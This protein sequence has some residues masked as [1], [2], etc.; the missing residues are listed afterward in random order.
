MTFSDEDLMAFADGEL[1][2]AKRRQI[3]DAINGDP[4]IARR[5]AAHRALRSAVHKSF[6]PVLEDPVPDRLISAARSAA[7][8][9]PRESKSNVVPLR[10]RGAPT[11][12]RPRWIALAASFILGALAL[13]LVTY[14]RKKPETDAQIIGSSVLQSAL[15]GQLASEPTDSPVQIGISYLSRSGNYCRTFRLHELSGLACNEA[16]NWKLQ[17]VARTA[18]SGSSEYRPAAS[19]TPAAILQAVNATASGEPLDSKSEAA[20][21]AQKWQ[22]AK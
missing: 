7:Q 20:A 2:D 1:D 3:Q 15:S 5:V 8:P 21:R 16:G 11:R 6:E 13:Q 14:L 10:R 17:V 22:H 9:A 19:D 18:G 4:E 12:Q